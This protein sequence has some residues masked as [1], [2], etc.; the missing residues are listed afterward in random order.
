VDGR[1]GF[2]RVLRAE[3]DDGAADV[4]VQDLDLDG[5]VVAGLADQGTGTPDGSLGHL[6]TCTYS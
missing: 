3:L 4:L 2:G 5:A 1:V 6:R